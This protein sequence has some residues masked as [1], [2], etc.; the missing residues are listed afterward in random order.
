MRVKYPLQS[1]VWELTLAC[2]FSCRYCGSSGGRARK[3][4]LTTAECFSVAE[5]LADLG[6]KRVSLI[7]GEVFM[8]SDWAEI[9]GKMIRCGMRV[10]IITN[11]FLFTSSLVSRLK[12]LGVESIA[13][14]LDGPEEIHDKY[15]QKGSFRRGEMAIDI[16]AKEQ[17]PVSVITTLHSKNS[18]YLP[19]FYEF[20]KSKPV[21]A[22]QIQACSPMGNAAKA[23]VNYRFDFKK[24]IEF[25]EKHMYDAP[26]YMGIADNIGYY[27]KAEGSLGGYTGGN[28]PFLGCKAGLT[29]LGI[30]S[31]GNV[32]GCE[33]MYADTF[34]EGNL[35]E[36]S[37]REIWEDPNTFAYNRVFRTEFLTGKCKGCNNGALC[38]G[39]CRSYNYFTHNHL[40][41]SL[42]CAGREERF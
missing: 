20:L 19:D 41:E 3:G 31:I 17:I 38:A 32:R 9:A 22:W 42:Y 34:I 35:R 23:G 24:V 29:T 8:R 25:V 7:G 28:A 26:F 12:E 1:C 40:Y 37:L 14:S 16:L 11:G 36:K 13:V 30:D 5:Q 10:A 15:R 33:S 6:C 21:F 27:T 4:E 2:C 18:L 39:G